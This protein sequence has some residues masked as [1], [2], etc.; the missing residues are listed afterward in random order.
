MM[1]WMAAVCI[2]RAQTVKLPC[3]CRVCAVPSIWQLALDRRWDVKMGAAPCRRAG[4]GC[5]SPQLY[6]YE[7]AG[8]TGSRWGVRTMSA[9]WLGSPSTTNSIHESADPPPVL[10]LPLYSC[11]HSTRVDMSMLGSSAVSAPHMNGQLSSVPHAA[12]HVGAR[13]RGAACPF[14][15]ETGHP[16]GCCGRGWR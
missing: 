7:E 13:Q 5:P 15:A 4:W 9:R 11:N 8:S 16:P 12:C 6:P 14:D 3:I 10:P 2:L 1:R